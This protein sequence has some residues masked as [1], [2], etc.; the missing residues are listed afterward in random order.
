MDVQAYLVCCK[1]EKGMEH[2]IINMLKSP[3]KLI[4]TKQVLKGLSEGTVRCVIVAADADSFIRNKIISHA[5]KH[6]AEIRHYGSMEALGKLCGIDVGA[7]VVG[8][9]K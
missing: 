3:S 1:K 5:N 7:A 9:M 2:E 6:N 8:M 4:G